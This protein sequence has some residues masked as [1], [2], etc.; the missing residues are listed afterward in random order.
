MPLVDIAEIEQK[1]FDYIIIGGL[2]LVSLLTAGLTLAARLAEDVTTSVLVLEAGNANEND[3]AISR[4]G[5][6]GSHFGQEAYSWGHTTVPQVNAAGRS[7]SWSRG[8]GLGGSSAIN[9]SCWTQPDKQDIDDWEKLGNAGWNSEN[10]FKY[11]SRTSSFKPREMAESLESRGIFDDW[12]LPLK[13]D[14]PLHVSFPKT[15]P[16][17]DVKFQR[18]LIN[19]GMPRSKAPL[20]GD[21]YGTFFTTNALDPTTNTRSYAGSV[22]FAHHQGLKNLS[23][24]LK[25]YATKVVLSEV[26][27]EQVATGVEFILSKEGD[28]RVINAKK[29]IILSAGTLKTPQILELSGIGMK[30]V[31]DNAGIP[32]VI[33]LPVG[34]NV[35]DHIF[36]SM[37]VQLKDGVTDL[38]FDDLAADGAVQK[39]IDLFAQG[40]GV[41]TV[42]I[43]N[44]SFF[45]LSDVSNRAKE[46]HKAGIDASQKK[47]DSGEYSL[48]AVTSLQMQAEKLS[49]FRLNPLLDCEITTL[50]GFLSGPNPPAAGKKHFSISFMN[51]HALSRGTIHIT[52]KDPRVDPA[53][54]PRYF[55]NPADLEVL[56]E[57]FK[58][59]RKV[60]QQSPF[61]EVLDSPAVEVNPGLNV[62][63][64][65]EIGAWIKQT[66]STTW[67]TLGA[68]S[69][70]PRSKGGVVDSKLKAIPVYGCK[71]LR[72]VDLSI[73]PLNVSCH[74]QSLYFLL[75][76]RNH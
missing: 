16:D 62:Q 56:I 14:G 50:P 51:N 1:T 55:E 7:L 27:G 15:L 47:I 19:A 20:S 68:C 46:I 71:N 76:S 63:T 3:A 5:Q 11:S 72:V 29:E 31:L 18:T 49:L 40:Q 24:L 45:P 64:D 38:T 13:S 30:A 61:N 42:G 10:F 39:H 57:L 12:T 37:S 69:M 74:T 22:Y 75:I 58:H 60:S 17:I 73:A 65:E 33:D 52:S 54:D 41:F 6:F 53:Y 48:G 32:T 34:E 66:F 21:P 44:F 8:R 26:Q 43:A 2:V 28:K 36:V 25:A 9:F 70:L 23:V 59:G 35:Q 67:H 4:P